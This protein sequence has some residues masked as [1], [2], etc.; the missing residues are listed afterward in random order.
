[1]AGFGAKYLQLPCI[2]CD[3]APS[4]DL[5][6]ASRLFP[7]GS[8]D[9]GDESGSSSPGLAACGAGRRNAVAGLHVPA[10]RRLQVPGDQR[11]LLPALSGGSRH[12]SE[13]QSVEKLSPP[14]EH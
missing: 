7:G 6:A 3:A 5:F 12:V 8:G 4:P 1:M 2:Y 10:V 9:F 11:V 13:V 14:T